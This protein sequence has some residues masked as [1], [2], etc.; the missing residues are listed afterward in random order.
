MTN[1]KKAEVEP[2]IVAQAAARALD[3]ANGDLQDA[4]ERMRTAVEGSDELRE[5]ITRPLL[6]EAC[7]NAVREQMRGERRSIWA[8]ARLTPKPAPVDTKRQASRVVQ[9]AQGTL[10]MFPLPG[11]V[12]LKD[13]TGRQIAEAADFY[14]RQARDMDTK[15]RWLRLVAQSVPDSA[16]AGDVMTDARLAELREEAD[17]VE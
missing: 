9:L 17:R 12:R 5:A 2:D 10:L 7:Y 13:A 8:D 15:A 14:A 16:V 3:D 11:G 1:A 4:T 6:R